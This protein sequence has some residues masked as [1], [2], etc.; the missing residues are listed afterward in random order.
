MK[1]IY[2]QVDSQRMEN[3]EEIPKAVCWEDGRIWKVDRVLHACKS[4]DGEF[5]GIRY[6]VMIG[7]AEK[8]IYRTGHSWYVMAAKGGV[9][10]EKAHNE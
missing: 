5:E 1:K 8:F 6:T 9:Q 7:K 3:G 4:L 10:V 2:V